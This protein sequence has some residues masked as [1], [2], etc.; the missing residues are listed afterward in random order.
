LRRVSA[1]AYFSPS[2]TSERAAEAGH[3]G[4]L[5]SPGD[6]LA[7]AGATAK[8]EALTGR[9]VGCRGGYKHDE[10]KVVWT[11]PLLSPAR[12]CKGSKSC[13]TVENTQRWRLPAGRLCPCNGYAG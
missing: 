5:F 11:L 8:R 12:L 6:S 4:F 9:C 3:H 13:G 7:S 2:L 1:C 10:Q